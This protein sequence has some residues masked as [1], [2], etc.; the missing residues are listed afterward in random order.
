MI[1]GVRWLGQSNTET[2]LKDDFV[3]TVA[4]VGSTAVDK[5]VEPVRWNH[6]SLIGDGLS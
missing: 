3:P 1:A 5:Y 6:I 4:I 2:L